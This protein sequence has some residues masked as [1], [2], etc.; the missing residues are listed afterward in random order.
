M[1]QR[2]TGPDYQEL[3]AHSEGVL[4]DPEVTQG[5]LN[6]HEFLQG[7]GFDAE[8]TEVYEAM[9]TTITLLSHLSSMMNPVVAMEL[10][11]R[12]ALRAYR[13]LNARG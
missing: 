7:S 3:I 4:D 12:F 8:S 13:D 2:Y 10:T 6:L 11:T 9:L 5:V 1:A